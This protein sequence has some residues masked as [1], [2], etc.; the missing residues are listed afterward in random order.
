MRNKAGAPADEV[1]VRILWW[2]E[3]FAP[4]VGGLQIVAEQMLRGLRDRGHQLAVLTSHDPADAPRAVDWEGI[5]VWR[6]PFWQ[7]LSSARVEEI[8]AVRRAVR[9]H[10]DAFAADVVHMH[11]FG[12]S[13]LF[14]LERTRPHGAPLVAALHSSNTVAAGATTLMRQTLERAGWVTACSR[15][16]LDA[17]CRAVPSIV[18]RASVVHNG[19]AAPALA[20]STL[21]AEPRVLCLGELA[22]HKGFDLAVRALPLLRRRYPSLRL[23]LAGDG[24]SRHDLEGLAEREGV[25]GATDFV[26]MVPHAAVPRLMNEATLVGIPSR[27]ETFGLVAVEAALMARPVVAARTGGLPEVVAHGETGLLVEA[28]SSAELAAA[29][30]ALLAA[31]RRAERLGR[32]ARRRALERFGVARQVGEFEDLYRRV[33]TEP[34]RRAEPQTEA[35]GRVVDGACE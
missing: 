35:S 31:P 23:V 26:G 21:P 16:L 10:A 29:I 9:S 1:P 22:P 34:D 33:A 25:A 11:G 27:R 20:P 19:A 14:L 28:E 30:D 12:P 24:P 17:A 18:A 4:G 6:L 8:A 13:V 7:V 2:Q 5:P 15:S 32:E 3:R